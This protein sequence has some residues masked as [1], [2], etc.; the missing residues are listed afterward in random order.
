MTE[1]TEQQIERQDE[2]D[3][4]IHNLL[5]HLAGRE[6]AHDIEKIGNVRDAIMDEFRDRGIMNELA[7]YPFFE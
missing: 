6:L 1:L 4:L 5:D 7:F 2:V 3:G